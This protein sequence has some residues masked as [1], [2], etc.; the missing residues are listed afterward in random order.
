MPINKNDLAEMLDERPEGVAE[1][2]WIWN[3]LQ[4]NNLQIVKTQRE[5][6]KYDFSND[7]L[8]H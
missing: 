6:D 1:V 2:N 5:E 4:T 7:N 8:L 3:W